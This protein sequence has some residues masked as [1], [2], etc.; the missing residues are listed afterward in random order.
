MSL[1]LSRGGP[2]NSAPKLPRMMFDFVD[3]AAGDETLSKINI[4]A[5]DR[6]RLMP[7]VLADVSN[8]DLSHK[9]FAIETGTHSESHRW[10]CAI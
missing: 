2:P 9:I 6:V 8:R 10:A 3:G 4:H 1:F 5:I 7:R